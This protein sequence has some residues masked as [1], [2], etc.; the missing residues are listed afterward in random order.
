VIDPPSA[1][2]KAGPDQ[3]REVAFRVR[4]AGDTPPQAYYFTA[5]AVQDLAVSTARRHFGLRPAAPRP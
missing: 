2:V 5:Y 4:F 3:E 1:R